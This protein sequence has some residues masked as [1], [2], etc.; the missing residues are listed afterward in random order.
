MALDKESLQRLVSAYV[1]G[2][3][4]ESIVSLEAMVRCHEE[5]IKA[6]YFSNYRC[7]FSGESKENGA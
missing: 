3:H 4:S 6:G 5:M 2:H 1:M 7:F